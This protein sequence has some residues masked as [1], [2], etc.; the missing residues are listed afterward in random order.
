LSA[1]LAF[2]TSAFVP[3][4]QSRRIRPR[5][6]GKLFCDHIPSFQIGNN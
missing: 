5:D 6:D 3:V 2:I 4:R 1:R